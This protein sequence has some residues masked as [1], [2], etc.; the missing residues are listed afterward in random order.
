MLFFLIVF[1]LSATLSSG[2]GFWSFTIGAVLLIIINVVY[3]YFVKRNEIKKLEKRAEESEQRVN[4]I[5]KRKAVKNRPVPDKIEKENPE[6][7]SQD[8]TKLDNVKR[9]SEEFKNA[10]AKHQESLQKKDNN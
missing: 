8:E 9:I 6:I 10:K 4:K 7:V 5:L 1:V 3:T 2:Y